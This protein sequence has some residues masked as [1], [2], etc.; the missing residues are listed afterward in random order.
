[1]SA[2][3]TQGRIVADDV[4]DLMTTDGQ[5]LGRSGFSDEAA[6]QL[7]LANASRLAACWNACIGFDTELLLNIVLMGDTLKQRFEGMQAEVR[8]VDAM[9]AK[10]PCQND[11]CA[12]LAATR[13]DLEAAKAQ[14]L[15]TAGLMIMWRDKAAENGN[16]LFAARTLLAEVRDAYDVDHDAVR[17]ALL[18]SIRAFL[19]GQL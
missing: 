10:R 15:S 9:L 4:G 1:M 5:Y 16:A 11:R 17:T 7:S 2:Q 19:K 6:T 8:R 12:E 14:S 13:A 18:D 3:H